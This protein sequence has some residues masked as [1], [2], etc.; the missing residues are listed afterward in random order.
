M[1]LDKLSLSE[2]K[3]L[4]KDVAKAIENFEVRKRNEA[5]AELEERAKELGFSLNELVSGSKKSKS[6]PKYRNPEEPSQ[7]WTGRGRKP[8]WIVAALD[9]GKDLSDYEI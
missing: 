6:L 7:T 3:S 4:Q 9:K 1:N 2:L 8:G 5:R